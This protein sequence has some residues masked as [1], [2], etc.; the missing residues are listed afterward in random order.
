MRSSWDSSLRLF[1]PRLQSANTWMRRIKDTLD[2]RWVSDAT[3]YL[4]RRRTGWMKA[5]LYLQP[6]LFSRL[7]RAVLESQLRL[8]LRRFARLEQKHRGR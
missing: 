8:A 4:P 5:F 3:M 2:P 6:L 1:G 7:G